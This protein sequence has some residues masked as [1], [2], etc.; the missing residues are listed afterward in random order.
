MPG[1]MT[2]DSAAAL[3]ALAEPRRVAMLRLVRDR[4]RSV[5]EIAGHFEDITQQAVSQHLRELRE[6]G[7]VAVHKDG[8]RRMYLLRPEGIERL[9]S[10]LRDLWPAGI[11]RLTQVAGDDGG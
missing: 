8:Q 7:L 6:A 5:G 11:D 3:K 1:A 2:Q 9:E 10:F 4:P